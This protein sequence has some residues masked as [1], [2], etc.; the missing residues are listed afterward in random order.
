MT[1]EYDVGGSTGPNCFK[2]CQSEQIRC[3]TSC[4]NGKMS[5]TFP[6]TSTSKTLV[7]IMPSWILPWSSSPTPNFIKSKIQNMYFF[8]YALIFTQWAK[9]ILHIDF[10]EKSRKKINSQPIM[11]SRKIQKKPISIQNQSSIL[12]SGDPPCLIPQTHKSKK[13]SPGQLVAEI[14]RFNFF[15]LDLVKPFWSKKNVKKKNHSFATNKARGMGLRGE[16]QAFFF[17]T[18][19]FEITNDQCTIVICT[20]FKAELDKIRCH[21]F[22]ISSKILNFFPHI[23][24]LQMTDLQENK[25]KK[26]I[27]EDNTDS[28]KSKRTCSPTVLVENGN[29][30]I[31]VPEGWQRIVRMRTGGVNV[32]K[33]DVTY[34]SPAGKTLRSKIG[35]EKYCQE[36]GLEIDLSLLKYTHRMSAEDIAD[37]QLKG[38]SELESKFIN[39]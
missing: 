12:I 2:L 8:D 28:P 38:V 23:M 31:Q 3:T 10:S 20:T 37:L 4:E 24:H 34:I 22:S 13:K 18:I 1:S 26:N 25:F 16:S 27:L 6:Y 19:T 32:G 11:N 35:V 17:G 21:D 15:S 30:N 5:H 7:L 36:N 14:W 39:Y 9:I 29:D 33:F